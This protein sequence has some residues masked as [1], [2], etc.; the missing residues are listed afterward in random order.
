ML[1]TEIPTSKFRFIVLVQLPKQ[2]KYKFGYLK[3]YTE[4]HIG[5]QSNEQYK[6]YT[7][8]SL[9]R[10]MSQ[11]QSIICNLTFNSIVYLMITV[12]P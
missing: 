5:A 3:I 9:I 4:N 1:Q 11:P 7:I 6:P 12:I 8:Y 10:H 2:S